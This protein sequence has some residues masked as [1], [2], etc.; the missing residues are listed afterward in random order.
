[1]IVFQSRPHQ[2]PSQHCLSY[3]VFSAYEAICHT[4]VNPRLHNRSFM[5]WKQIQLSIGACKDKA[6]N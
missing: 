1:M 4:L 2:I 5:F 6:T 3:E